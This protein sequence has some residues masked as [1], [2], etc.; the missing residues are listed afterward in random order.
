MFCDAGHARQEQTDLAV[1]AGE[2]RAVRGFALSPA[3]HLQGLE[4][5]VIFTFYF[6][7]WGKKKFPLQQ[8][9][10]I[11][12]LGKRAIS[13]LGK[14]NHLCKKMLKWL[15]QRLAYLGGRADSPEC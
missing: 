3:G 13:F 1:R 10:I 7:F 6:I 9:G 8:S 15:S 2:L 14:T 4:L 5:R 11:F 12:V